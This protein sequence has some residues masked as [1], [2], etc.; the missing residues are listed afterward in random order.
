ML[1]SELITG[2]Q[3]SLEISG[4]VEVY[5]DKNGSEVINITEITIVGKEN[6]DEDLSDDIIVLG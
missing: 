6:I 2:L 1:L 3:E 4:D 5:F